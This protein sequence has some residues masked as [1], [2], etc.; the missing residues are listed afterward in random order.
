QGSYNE[1]RPAREV[2]SE[3]RP[4]MKIKGSLFLAFLTLISIVPIAQA[5]HGGFAAGRVVAPPP[6]IVSSPVQ[7]FVT[8]PVQPF[9]TSPVQPLV[10]SPVQPFVTSPV[11]PFG[12]PQT[13]PGEVAPGFAPIPGP[14]IF[15]PPQLGP[16]T[17]PPFQS[18]TPPP[19]GTEPMVVIPGPGIVAGPAFRSPRFGFARR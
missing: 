14:V 6:P 17:L 3:G 18:I 19:F 12:V 5:Q 15:G 1:I 7:P 8:S 4:V 10:T 11:G 2:E 9:V 16:A 13:F